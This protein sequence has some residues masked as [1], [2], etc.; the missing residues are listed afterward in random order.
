[1]IFVGVILAGAL[2]AL[3]IVLLGGGD[4]DKDSASSSGGSASCATDS[5]GQATEF[6]LECPDIETPPAEGTTAT[7][8]TSEG[9]FTIDLA[10]QEAPATSA[11]FVY[12]AENGVYKD[13]SFTRI[14][15]GFVIQGGDPSGTGAGG[16][17]YTVT[18]APPSDEAYPVGT[19]AMAKAGTEPAGASGSQFFVVI[20]T[21]SPLPP[22]YALL[23]RV[24]A[25]MD[26]VEKIAAV[27][28]ESG[29]DG[30]PAQPI[31]INDVTINPP[32]AAGG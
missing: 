31:A 21:A 4:D 14:A 9:A 13:N 20:G 29:S 6:Q 18:E 28:T 1:M 8:E 7:V 11:S 5:E 23:G 26:V 16:A 25:G 2:V 22:D 15:P 24:G 32:A 27:G 10:T 30:P 3:A 19:V 12:M 17:G